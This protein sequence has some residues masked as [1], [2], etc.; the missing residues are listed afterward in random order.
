MAYLIINADDFGYS[1]IFNTKI[2]ELLERRFVTSTSVMVNWINTDQK[3]QLEE[4]IKLKNSKN[5]SVGLHIEFINQS[6]KTQIEEQYRKFI[7]LFG[8]K[9]THLDIHKLTYM[10]DG[11]PKIMEFCSKNDMPCKKYDVQG[12]KVITTDEIVYVGTHKSF[13]EIMEW[14]KS[15][16]ADKTYLIEFHPG[17]FDSK[18]KSSYNKVREVDAEM[19]ERMVPELPKY[20]V[21][22]IN[23]SF[24]TK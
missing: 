19:I 6:F 20:G 14:I 7:S 10:E 15:L 24:L 18:S 1:K 23:Y 3:S 5:V 17:I 16:E 9:P 4:L 11:Y 13:E 2:L 8:F 21:K 12:S 22:L